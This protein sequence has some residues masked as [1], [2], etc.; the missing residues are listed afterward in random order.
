MLIDIVIFFY[1]GYF[2][3]VCCFSCGGS[4]LEWCLNDDLWVEYVYWFLECMF[5]I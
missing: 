2:D 5:V 4:L 1:L 3:C